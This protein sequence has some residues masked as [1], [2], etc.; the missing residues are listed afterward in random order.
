MTKTFGVQSRNENL[1]CLAN[2]SLA[3]MKPDLE[4]SRR[5]R[6]IRFQSPHVH[7]WKESLNYLT[8]LDLFRCFY[9]IVLVNCLCPNA[10]IEFLINFI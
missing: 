10:E 4:R 3:N 5:I 1:N 6:L 9:I 8:F 7:V 2:V